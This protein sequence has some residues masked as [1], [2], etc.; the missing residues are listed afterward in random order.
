[1]TIPTVTWRKAIAAIAATLLGLLAVVVVTRS[2]G[3]PAVDASSSRA[4][5][6][7]VHQ[8]TG[9]VVLVDGYG[10]RALAS[11]D[12]GPQGEQISVAQGSPGAYLLNETTAE[13]RAID[14]AGLTLGSPV[15]LSSL[16]TGRAIAAVGQ[17]GLVV[18]NPD[19]EV[20]VV[21]VGDESLSFPVDSGEAVVIAPDGAVWS[22]VDGDLRRTTSTSTHP[23]GPTRRRLSDALDGGEPA[24]RS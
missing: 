4:T 8:P 18:V 22:L 23:H 10:G 20:T 17:A 12:V 6:W 16:G 11:M 5:Y 24:V 14:T 9:R 21:P 1:V 15:G 13:A 3:L 7:F 19:D 2:D